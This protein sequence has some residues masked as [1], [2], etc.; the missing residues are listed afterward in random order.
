LA[1]TDVLK[2]VNCDKNA[3]SVYYACYHGVCEDHTTI[4]CCA[5]PKLPNPIKIDNNQ[6]ELSVHRN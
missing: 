1:H 3:T 2:C 5:Q 4:N 6:H